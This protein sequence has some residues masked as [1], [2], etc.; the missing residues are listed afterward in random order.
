MKSIEHYDALRC[1]FQKIR[2]H[3][4]TDYFNCDISSSLQL[5]LSSYC[6]S[7]LNSSTI[8][9][10]NLELIFAPQLQ[11]SS[12]SGN[13]IEEVCNIN[14]DMYNKKL[15]NNNGKM[16]LVNI[17]LQTANLQQ[18][19]FLKK[20][21]NAVMRKLNRAGIQYPSELKNFILYKTFNL[22][23]KV[24]SDSGFHQTTQQGF[25]NLINGNKGFC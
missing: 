24:S 22:R 17:C 5:L 16:N 18:K 12:L 10:I 4:S 6:L 20:L 23:L 7:L 11:K 8:E 25:L 2:I 9:S 3:N 1:K 13:V 19:S 21:T 15:N 14:T